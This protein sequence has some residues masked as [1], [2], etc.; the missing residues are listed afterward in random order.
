MAST[1]SRHEH[2]GISSYHAPPAP[3][4]HQGISAG[5][6]ARIQAMQGIPIEV[7][8]GLGKGAL[9]DTAHMS[10][11][12][13][14]SPINITGQAGKEAIEHDLL[15]RATLADQGPDEVGQGQFAAAREGVGVL[16]KPCGLGEGIAV[17]VLA[18]VTEKMRECRAIRPKG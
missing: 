1:H 16:G 12:T 6:Q 4:R 5:E 8:A 13:Q 14:R 3:A 18:Q 7:A 10:E 15:G 17:D 2:T 11:S 9:R